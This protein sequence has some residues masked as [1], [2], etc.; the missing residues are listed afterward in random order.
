M[1]LYCRLPFGKLHKGNPEIIALS[2]VIERTPSS[3]AMKLCNLASLDPAHQERGV[4][5]LSGASKGDRKIWQEFH[6]DWDRLAV[7]SESLRETLQRERQDCNDKRGP[8]EN[9]KAFEGATETTVRARARRAQS[10]FRRAV[11]ASYETKCCI[12]GIEISEMLIASH[13]LP[14]AEYPR[15]RA[16][17]RNGFCLSRLHDAAFDR[18]LITFDEGFRLVLS[19]ELNE[20]TSNQTLKNCFKGFEGQRITLPSRFRP[21]Q[22]SIKLHRETIF[23]DA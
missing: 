12:T 8:E 23:V 17:P 19:H 13:I 9:M 10:F 22:D 7:E 5:G 11:F 16:D 4:K 18:G 6:D 15:Y 1:N 20:A 2:A 14:G 21:S 3:V